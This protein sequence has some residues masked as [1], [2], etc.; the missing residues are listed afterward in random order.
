[1]TATLSPAATTRGPLIK[2]GRYRTSA[3]ER[4]LVARRVN[5]TV[6]IIDTPAPGV[7]GRRYLLEPRVDSR[8]ELLAIVRDYLIESRDR[9]APAMA[10]SRGLDELLQRLRDC[11]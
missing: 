6:G 9:R 1:M 4:W 10:L 3:G 2:L 7:P 8:A 5:G 11:A